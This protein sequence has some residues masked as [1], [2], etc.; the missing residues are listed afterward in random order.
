MFRLPNIAILL[1]RYLGHA[2]SERHLI[3]E[4]LDCGNEA[5]MVETLNIWQ[6]PTPLSIDLTIGAKVVV[7]ASSSTAGKEGIVLSD[8]RQGTFIRVTQQPVK[9]DVVYWTTSEQ[10]LNSSI[11]GSAASTNGG[12][13]EIGT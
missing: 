1:G 4:L 3:S 7:G 13:A 9:G 8:D 12:A 11:S 2:V 5:E 10:S 6:I